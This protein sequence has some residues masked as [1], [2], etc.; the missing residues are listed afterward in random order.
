[1]VARYAAMEL[2]SRG[3]GSGELMIISA[4]NTLRATSL[5]SVVCCF[6]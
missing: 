5:S 2:A 4:D 1:M 3:W 6:R